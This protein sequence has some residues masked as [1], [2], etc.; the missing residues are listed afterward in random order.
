MM[1]LPPPPDNIMEM[2]AADAMNLFL[3][4]MLASGASEKTI[5]SYRS[6]IKDFITVSGIKRVGDIDS[7]RII[8]WVN[9]RLMEGFRG[10]DRR[11][12]QATMHYYTIF[13]RKWLSWIGYPSRIVPVVKKPRGKEFDVLR[14]DEIRQLYSGVKDVL[15]KLILSLLLETGLRANELL[16]LRIEDV[17]LATGEVRVRNAKYGKERTVFLGPISSAVIR[18][19]IV[20]KKRGEKLIPLSY[21]GLYKRLKTIAKRSGLPVEKVRPHI[22]RHTFATQAIRKGMSLPALQR[23]L[24]HSDIKIT[25][26]YMHLVKEDLRREYTRVFS[27]QSNIEEERSRQASDGFIFC[28]NCGRRIPASSKYCPY[29]GS[30]IPSLPEVSNG[31]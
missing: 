30:R 21:N 5:L 11:K 13:L 19:Y 14:D 10:E 23:L 15:D 22:L 26:I 17:D 2:D 9:Y 24:G 4:A 28:P 7:S 1:P 18:E 20:D 8:R 6:A 25:E 31:T 16:S 29:C 27:V 12:R 3:S